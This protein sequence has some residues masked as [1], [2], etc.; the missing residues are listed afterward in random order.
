MSKL[1]KALGVDKNFE[2]KVK[3]NINKTFT[4]YSK[5]DVVNIPVTEI[6]LRYSNKFINDEKTMEAL[7]HSIEQNGLLQPILVIEIEKYITNKKEEKEYLDKMLKMGYKY[8][9]SSG[10]RRYKAYL[11]LATNKVVNNDDDVLEACTYIKENKLYE[12]NEKYALRNENDKKNKW[13]YI[14]CSLRKTDKEESIYS[15]TNLTSRAVTS[16]ERIVNASENVEEINVASIQAY[17][18]NKYGIIENEKTIRNILAC[19][20]TL[21]EPFLKAVYEGKLS[22]RDAKIIAGKYP[23]IK[24]KNKL[25]EDIHNGTLDLSSLSNKRQKTKVTKFTKS[26]LLNYLNQIKQGTKTVDEILE[27]VKKL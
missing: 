26:Q 11:S 27:I 10:H 15:D 25:L 23:Q 22:Q 1:N 16:F 4:G 9:I 24:N 2:T 5:D 14:P 7:K 20:K 17:I 21:D 18:E 19:I 3:S 6:C 12:K 8:F 13:L